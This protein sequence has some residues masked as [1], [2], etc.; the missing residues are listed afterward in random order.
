MNILDVILKFRV[1]SASDA[2]SRNSYPISNT[3]LWLTSR[4]PLILW[5]DFMT[6]GYA[7]SLTP[8]SLAL[9]L[10]LFFKNWWNPLSVFLLFPPSLPPS[11]KVYHM[12]LGWFR[13]SCLLLWGIPLYETLPSLSEVQMQGL[14]G[15]GTV[16]WS[17]PS[18]QAV[19]SMLLSLF[20]ILGGFCLL[21]TAKTREGAAALQ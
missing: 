10:F 5:P 13:K 14:S 1:L 9:H 20:S 18:L 12:F 8:C 4:F 19:F 2:S 17:K 16:W 15:C 3:S 7:S 21:G 11:L 6:T